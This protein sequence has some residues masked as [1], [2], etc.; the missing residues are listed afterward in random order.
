[1]KI[2]S[3]SYCF[4]N[5]NNP[6]WGM[7]VYQRLAA[8][9]KYADLKVCSP[10][11]WFPLKAT[12]ANN[13]RSN[14]EDWNGL[15]TYRPQFFYFPGILKNLDGK[16]YARGLRRWLE[17]FC[18]KWEP[19]ILDAHFVWPDGVGVAHLAETVGIPYAITLRGK[20]YECLKVNSQ[21][22][23]CMEALHGASAVIAVSGLLAEEARKLG[24]PE[25]KLSVI[26]NGIDNEMLSPSD[27]QACRRE[28]GLP[29]QGRIMVT[30]AHLG[31]RKGHFEVVQALA[32]LPDD[33][34]LVLVGGGAQGGSAEDLRKAAQEAGVAER[35]HVPG[36]QP[37][38]RISLYFNAADLSVLASYR[39]GCPNAVLESLACGTP[40]V[41]TDVG[42]VRDI[43][44]EP[45][46]GRI[47][48]PQTVDPLR[49][50]LAEALDQEWDKEAVFRAS[51]VR[52]W[53][54][55]AQDVHNVLEKAVRKEDPSSNHTNGHE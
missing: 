5:K 33:V 52:S 28:L 29:L 10:V 19:D 46:C 26:P 40:V 45:E 3:F 17:S 55:V 1:M 50:A 9:A 23:Q 30:V 15:H 37:Y 16:L 14:G 51:G 4:P 22:K 44:P 54:Q 20:L 21:A 47:V 11:P 32:G 39:E 42:A 18:S 2:L 12:T 8:L 36:P 25:D 31:H 49:E 38:E 34:H 41:A 43:L 6:T 53:R 24:V 27:K 35:L 48:P 7:F 13:S